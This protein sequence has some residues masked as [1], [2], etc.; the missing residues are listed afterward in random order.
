MDDSLFRKALGTSARLNI[1]LAKTDYAE[2]GLRET[3]F[4]LEDSKARMT[5][6]QSL[7]HRSHEVLVNL[8]SKQIDIDQISIQCD[9][10]CFRFHRSSAHWNHGLVRIK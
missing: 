6:Q 4:Q 10:A 5:R 1:E 8:S 3:Q 2:A 7:Q 9:S